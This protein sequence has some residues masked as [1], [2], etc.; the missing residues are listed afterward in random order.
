M[1]ELVEMSGPCTLHTTKDKKIFVEDT[2]LSG[3]KTSKLSISVV[4]TV[5]TN[6]ESSQNITV[7]AVTVH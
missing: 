3:R 1:R 5:S 6:M 4:F 7:T 2:A